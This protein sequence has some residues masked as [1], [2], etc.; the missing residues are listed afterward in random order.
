MPARLAPRII[1]GLLLQDMRGL[2]D[3]RLGLLEQGF[4]K[5]HCDFRLESIRGIILEAQKN[6]ALETS[7]AYCE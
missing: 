6:E 7:A 5:L 1:Q 2:C 3:N 4:A